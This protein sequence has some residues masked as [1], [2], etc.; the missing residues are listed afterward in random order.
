MSL[1]TRFKL[2]SI[3]VIVALVFSALVAVPAF[4]D[5][6]VPPAEPLISVEEGGDASDPADGLADASDATEPAP[7]EIAPA[8]PAE[9]VAEDPAT[10]AATAEVLSD[11]PD[12]TTVAVVNAA[13]EALPLATEEAAEIL[14]AADPIWCPVSVSTPVDALSG[15]SPSFPD[16]NGL[17]TWLKANE[18]AM[19]GVIWI[20]AGA[21]SSGVAELELDGLSETTLANYKLT[22]KGGWDG[23]GTKTIDT[24][25]PS[26]LDGRLHILNWLNDVTLSDILITGAPVSVAGE[27]ALRVTTT[28]KITLTR[29]RVDANAGSGALLDN[30]HLTPTPVDVLIT[31]SQFSDNANGHGLRVYSDGTITLAGVIAS[32]NTNG[33]GAYLNNTAAGTA[34]NV[35]MT[36]GVNEF[37][38]ND[39]TGLTVLT[40]GAITLKDITA[41]GNGDGGGYLD[42]T[43]GTAGITLS[44]VNVFSENAGRGLYASSNGAIS[45]NSLV[46]NA[47]GDYAVQANNSGA[48]TAQPV[49]LTGTS[50]FKYNLYG[51]DILSNGAIT[52]SNVTA[53]FTQ[54]GQGASLANAI[55][56]NTSGV[57]LTGVNVFSENHV[58]G[59]WVESYG[60]ISLS[61][62]TANYNGLT[63]TYGYG[64]YLTNLGAATA[65]AITLSGTNQFNGNY[66]GG[67]IV[68]SK[69]AVT[70]SKVT[71]NDNVHGTGA[72]VI[73]TYGPSNLPQNVTLSGSGAFNGNYYT[74]LDISTYGVIT[75]ANLTA[76]FNG[77]AG[78]GWTGASLNNSSGSIA[79]AVTLTGTNTFDA[80]TAYGLYSDS[81]GAI[82]VNNLFAWGNTYDGV[83]L[84]NAYLASPVAVNGTSEFTE[85]GSNGLLV[86]S[87]GNITV[88]NFDAVGNGNYGVHLFNTY[89]G[90]VGNVTAGTSKSGWCNGLWDNYY[91]G[92]DVRS[93]GAVTLY[94][95]CAWSN[96][97]SSS[98]GD[99]VYVNNEG[100]ATP[101]AVTIKG[102]NT[103]NDNYSYGLEVFSKGPIVTSSL[104]ASGN[105]NGDGARLENT[106]A[107]AAAPQ[108]ITLTG[109]NYFSGN[110]SNGLYIVSYG[111]IVASNVT[112]NEN[113][114]AYGAQLINSWGDPALHRSVSLPGTNTFSGN[115][116]GGLNVSSMGAIA[117]SNVRA[118][119]NV[120]GEGASLTNGYAL[121]TGGLT[122]GGTSNVFSGNGSFGLWVQTNG[123]I[124]AA[125]LRAEDNATYGARLWNHTAAAPA[126]V[127][128]TGASNGFDSNGERG[129]DVASMGAITIANLHASGNDEYGAFLGN[130]SSGVAAPQK[131]T[132]SGSNS[133]N[134]NWNIGLYVSSHGAVTLN[135]LTAMDNG[136]SASYG[137]GVIIDAYDP[138]ATIASPVTLTGYGWF[139]AN[140][141]YGLYVEA[142]GAIKANNL[143]TTWNGADGVV[144][145]NQYDLVTSGVTLTGL[146]AFGDNGS[147]GLYVQ[148]NGAITLANV[149]A[150]GNGGNG[151]YLDTYG[152][153]SPQKVTLTGTN[154]FNGNGSTVAHTGDGLLLNAD[155]QITISNLTA[156]WNGRSGAEL[157][158]AAYGGTAT[159]GLTLSGVNN[160]EGNFYDG[161]Y[162]DVVGAVSLS[163]I[164]ADDNGLSGVDGTTF[165]NITIT[166]GSMTGNGAYGWYLWT[167]S[168]V[169]LKGVFSYGNPINGQVAGGGT[170]V[171]YRTCS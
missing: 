136:Q 62:V 101:K 117:V 54:A 134:Q 94:N 27:A 148:S 51:L 2:T 24:T 116:G 72:V 83:Y 11:L 159:S 106:S 35:V 127:T 163:K 61:S 25:D 63:N 52:V 45:L 74:G 42:N 125:G 44:G 71:A 29:V 48:A 103:F 124:S 135:N 40:K 12:G 80:N 129:L 96:G 78:L 68:L 121:G 13:G 65:K 167:P 1:R 47:N 147:N 90:A 32:D 39:W 95:M 99:G 67:L 126:P 70:L 28:G 22:L 14:A 82:T 60:A 41:D 155:G 166:C 49:K 34:K 10:D 46:A 18:P 16:L 113:N 76:S 138:A 37:N 93:Y 156:N 128:L 69:G 97:D 75:G 9:T 141:E 144:L 88:Q 110:S 137:S 111:A 92:I 152:L 77:V 151:A 123:A 57:T 85:N 91:S 36:S 143:T 53:S 100:A 23:L 115:A 112:A 30:R 109:T 87:R 169:T 145:Y 15:C 50:Q 43:Y 164:T 139:E 122:L 162:F 7:T 58:H 165:G 131:V 64:A 133:F 19:D 157:D 59:L 153:L 3:S 158:N 21:D 168:V 105:L 79:K 146:N 120:A 114:G 73:N 81:L 5:D 26:V 107:G 89:S 170:L 118:E 84:F 17:F 20:E 119:G 140:L 142:L 33:Y 130:T 31:L 132:L 150:Y 56:T 66:I 4:A 104:S 108:N 98:F 55:G 161:L 171:V 8:D 6:G 149:T 154:T 102:T 160:F 38:D 86:Y